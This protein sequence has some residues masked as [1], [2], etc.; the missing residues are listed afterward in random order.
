MNIKDA[1]TPSNGR[2]TMCVT[3][4]STLKIIEFDIKFRI[5]CKVPLLSQLAHRE[6]HSGPERFSPIL[7]CWSKPIKDLQ[8]LGIRGGRRITEPN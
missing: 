4:S 3:A 6:G 1:T 5:H 8:G 7:L 2:H